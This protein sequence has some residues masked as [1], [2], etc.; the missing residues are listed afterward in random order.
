MLISARPYGKYTSFF[1]PPPVPKCRPPPRH[2]ILPCPHHARHLVVSAA[3]ARWTFGGGFNE[4]FEDARKMG[5]YRQR[6]IYEFARTGYE[7]LFRLAEADAAYVEKR[8]EE[9]ETKAVVSAP[10]GEKGFVIGVHVRHG[11]CHPLEFQYSD[12]YIPLDRYRDRVVD[13]SHGEL[14]SSGS[15]KSVIKEHG[16]IVIASDDP[17]VYESEEFSHAVRAQEQ[18][19]LASKNAMPPAARDHA[20]SDSIFRRFVDEAVGWEG[21]FFASMFWNLGQVTMTSTSLVELPDRKM[22][23]TEEVLRLRELV[24]R[25]Y[26]MDLAVLGSASD[27]VVCTVSSVGCRLLAV[28]M[29][30]ESAFD[31]KGWVNIDGEFDWKGVPW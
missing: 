5:V 28:I 23:P 8:I 27:V 13:I 22:P 30:W 24:G 12:S 18:I 9:I 16:A 31:N 20:Q 3:T 4:Y 11:D 14:N 29:G 7:A 6:P 2:E 17:D 25:A 19:R 10:K 1:E 21:G 26:L 15:L